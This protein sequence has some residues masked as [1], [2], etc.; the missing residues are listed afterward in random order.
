MSHRTILAWLAALLLIAAPPAALAAQTA[1]GYQTGNGV[2]IPVTPA[3]PLPTATG[4]SS[5]LNIT[6]ATVIKAAPGRM[7]RISVIVAGSAVGSV[8]DVATTGAAAVGNQIWVIPNA[9][10]MTTIEWP[11]LVGIVVVPG[12]GQ[13]LAVSFS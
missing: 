1:T 12:T 8:N 3:T 7:V 6:V 9:V 2:T 10:G 13:T 5:T 11:C 4:F